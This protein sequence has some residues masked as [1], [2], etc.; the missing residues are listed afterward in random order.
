MALAYFRAPLGII[1]VTGN[2]SQ[3]NSIGFI[4]Q[5]Y[6]QP[7]PEVPAEVQRCL[8]QLEQYFAGTLKEFKLNLK[9]EGTAFQKKVWHALLQIRYGRTLSYLQLARQLGDENSLRAVGKANGENKLAI[10][11]PCHR[12]VGANGELTGYA[13]GVDKKEWLLNHEKAIMPNRQLKLF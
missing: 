10:V 6:D 9:Q 4:D 11:V 2:H 8:Q 5:F 3:V 12:V 7:S 13:G 1:A